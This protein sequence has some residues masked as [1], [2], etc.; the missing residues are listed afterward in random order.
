M[1]SLVRCISLFDRT[2]SKKLLELI[3]RETSIANETAHGEGVHGVV[4]GN[5]EDPSTIGHHDMFT[6]AN[7][8][9][10]DLLEGTHCLEMPDSRKLGLHSHL[11]LAYVRTRGLLPDHRK[12]LGDRRANVFEGLSLGG[13]L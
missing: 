5:G 6:L 7:H 3:H 12:V 11:N 13:A 1:R 4:P 2:R 10:A 9:E 8:L